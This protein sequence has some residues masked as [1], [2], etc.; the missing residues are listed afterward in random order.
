MEKF[1]IEYHHPDVIHLLSNHLSQLLTQ[2]GVP[3]SEL[4]CLCIGTDRSTGD[5]L[6]PLV[7]TFL[8]EIIQ[9]QLYI[10]GTLDNP[11]H[12]INLDRTITKIQ[13]T[14]PSACILTIDATLGKQKNIGFINLGLGP[15]E[16]GK[17]LNKNLPSIG[18]IYLKG[19]VNIVGAHKIYIL[20]NTRLHRVYQMAKVISLAILQATERLN[21]HT[22]NP[23]LQSNMLITGK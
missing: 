19:I 3:D 6:G 2:K 11:I 7:G 12:A 22:S 4:V 5:S 8:S 9:N 14:H 20:Q 1:Q 18:D 21:L 17:G 15:L 23:P 13:Q 16:P 10:Y